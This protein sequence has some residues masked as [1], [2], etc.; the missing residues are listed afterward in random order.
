MSGALP[1]ETASLTLRRFTPADARE[2]LAMS[3]QPGLRAW[4]PD[5]VY[6]DEREAADVLRHLIAQYDLPAAPVTAPLVL[7]VCLRPGAAL[8]GHVGLSPSR[9]VVEIGYAIDDAHQGRGLATEAVR[10][11][12]DWGIRRFGLPGVDGIVAADN[13]GSCRVLEKAGFVL[14]GEAPR[15]LHGVTRRVR[16]YRRRA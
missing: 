1:I 9:D 10:A 7:G 14:V 15:P 8:I 13:A 5:Q 6:A 11:M 3:R 12:A 2:V 4:L 16:T